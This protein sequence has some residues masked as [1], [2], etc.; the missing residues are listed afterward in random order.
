MVNPVVS[1]IIPAY[2]TEKYVGDCLKSLKGQTYTEIEIIVV[3]DGSTDATNS[4][5]KDYEREDKRF[6]VITKNNSGVSDSRNKG[7]QRAE[8]KYIVF[9]DSDDY[10][11]Q[12]YIETL[13]AEIEASDAQMAC[14]DYYMVDEDHRIE[15]LAAEWALQCDVQVMSAEEAINLLPSKEAFQGYL[16]N[17]IFVKEIIQENQIA[18]DPEIK[19]WEDML[20]CLKYLTKIEKAAYSHKRIYYY[21]QRATSAMNNPRTW[22]EHTHLKALEEMWQITRFI[23]GDFREYIQNFYAN[24]LVGLLGKGN[25]AEKQAIQ[26]EITHIERLK[27]KLSLKHRV[28]FWIY[29]YFGILFSK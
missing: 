17:K 10:V 18:F 9:V 26:K 22:S 28:K 14:A 3:D 8:G 21:V 24:D 12:D 19:I 20:F 25:F 1:V 5:C 7:M 29:K 13:V 6:K 15:A 16:W 2:N 4:I 27:G 23:D 11:A